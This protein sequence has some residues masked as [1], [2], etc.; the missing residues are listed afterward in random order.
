MSKGRNF[1]NNVVTARQQ[2]GSEPVNSDLN[3]LAQIR[4]DTARWI[5]VFYIMADHVAMVVRRCVVINVAALRR[6]RLVLGWVTRI[7]V[8]FALSWY[9]IKHPG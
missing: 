4:K 6:V 5:E 2:T 8:T 9:L 3:G 7:R 1:G